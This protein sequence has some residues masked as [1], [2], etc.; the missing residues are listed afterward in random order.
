MQRPIC[1][2]YR[3]TYPK[4]SRNLRSPV[5][6]HQGT[7]LCTL[8]LGHPG[9]LEVFQPFP[10]ARSKTVRVDPSYTASRVADDE[11]STGT[12]SQPAM[13]SSGVA[14]WSGVASTWVENFPWGCGE[15]TEQVPFYTVDLE[16][17]MQLGCRG[18][19]AVTSRH[20]SKSPPPKHTI[21]RHPRHAVRDSRTREGNSNEH[22]HQTNAF[23]SQSRCISD[24][25]G[26]EKPVASDFRDGYEHSWTTAIT[27]G[28]RWFGFEPSAPPN[29]CLPT[30]MYFSVV[31][32]MTECPSG[33]NRGCTYANECLRIPREG[34]ENPIAPSG[35]I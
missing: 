19:I 9:N 34:A 33:R 12:R 24:P 25:R 15:Y 29:F 5:T 31:R 8:L 30:L 4:S 23:G 11:A 17:G 18:P 14:M 28:P 35:R 22:F 6:G 21:L 3:S 13:G 10:N 27:G 2:E 20:N 1:A 7:N 32:T 26:A 16:S